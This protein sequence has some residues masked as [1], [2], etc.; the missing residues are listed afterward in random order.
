M[1]RPIPQERTTSSRL[2][3]FWPISL[4]GTAGK[5]RRFGGSISG[6]AALSA[7]DLLEERAGLVRSVFVGGSR[8]HRQGADPS[9]SLPAAGNRNSRRRGAPQSRRRQTRQGRGDLVRRRARVDIK[10]RQDTAGLHPQAVFAHSYVDA[11]VMAEAL[12]RIG[13][14]VADQRLRGDGPYQAARDLL[15]S[16]SPRR[17]RRAARIAQERRR[18]RPPFGSAAIWRAAF[19]P[20]QGPPGAGKTF[21]GA[22]MICELVRRGKNSRHHGQQP[23]G[24]SQPDRCDHQGRRRMG[25]D[26]QCCQKADEVE[27][28]QH[29]FPSPRAN[30]DL[31]AALGGSVPLSAAARPGYGRG[32]TRSKPSTCFSS[33]KPRRCRSP[34]CSRCRRRRR[35]SC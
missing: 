3:G 16:E 31:L 8:R 12:V 9:L 19:C 32:R 33:T 4:I 2:V 28:P 23:Q 26:L 35:P 10:K 22:Q 21:T 18:L 27:A 7:E 15:L 1:F 17:R 6:L 25:L 14:Y 11:K 29:R 13:E 30:E 20:I 24:H 34:T 5:K